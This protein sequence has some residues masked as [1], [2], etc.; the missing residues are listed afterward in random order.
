LGLFQQVGDLVRV[1]PVSE[2][3]E[4]LDDRGK[5]GR[6]LFTPEMTKFAGKQFRVFKVVRRIILESNGRL[7]A[8]AAPT[9]LLED[10]FCDGSA[11]GSC[12]R[13]CFCFW[14][15]AWLTNVASGVGEVLQIQNRQ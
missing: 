13:T 15:E 10:V 14:R 9:M 11:H 6:L 12:D 3:L 8:I 1:K 5:L 4:T 2:T 7:R